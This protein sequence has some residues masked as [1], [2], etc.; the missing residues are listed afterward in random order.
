MIFLMHFD[1]GM[2]CVHSFW[3]LTE[4]GWKAYREVAYA[5]VYQDYSPLIHHI[6]DNHQVYVLNFNHF[7]QMITK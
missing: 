5:K 4:F 2:S 1:L 7:Y 3:L 6:G